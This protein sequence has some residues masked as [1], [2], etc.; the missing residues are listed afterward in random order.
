VGGALYDAV[1]SATTRQAEATLLTRD[2]RASTV[3][4]WAGV[5]Y[6]LVA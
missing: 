2:R 3:Y 1:V 4:G 6:E 5:A